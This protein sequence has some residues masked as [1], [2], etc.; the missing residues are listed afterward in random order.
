M[1]SEREGSIS[2]RNSNLQNKG[3]EPEHSFLHHMYKGIV[4]DKKKRKEIRGKIAAGNYAMCK[5]SSLST[6]NNCPISA[7]I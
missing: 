2:P 5:M 4:Y 7:R 6:P 3:S 1:M